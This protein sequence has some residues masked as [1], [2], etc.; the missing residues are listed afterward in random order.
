MDGATP[1]AAGGRRPPPEVR[2][3]N[4]LIGIF[5]R[6]K[7]A[8]NLLMLIMI[9]AG[10]VSLQRMTT[11]F[12]PDF[13]IDVVMITVKWPGASAND[14]DSNVVQAIEPEV[15]FLDGV[16][17]VKSSSTEGVAVITIEFKTGTDMQ[18]ALSNAETAV[19]QITTLPEG[20][21]RPEIRKIVRYEPLSRILVT[22][23]Y[24]EASL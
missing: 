24:S 9:L 15:R 6:H 12:F 7:T 8:A 22:G 17:E 20:S 21:E 16:K 19:R 23:P 2:R 10:I 5:A 4:D 3:K 11:Q 1:A 14:V 18:A 13:G